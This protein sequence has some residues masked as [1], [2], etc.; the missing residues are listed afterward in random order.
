[1]EFRIDSAFILNSIQ[2]IY[3]PGGASGKEPAYQCIRR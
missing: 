2:D 3:F 1:M